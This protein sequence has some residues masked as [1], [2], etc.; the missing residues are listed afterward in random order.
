M[1]ICG[2]ATSRLDPVHGAEGSKLV[3]RVHREPHRQGSNQHAGQNTAEYSANCCRSPPSTHCTFVAGVV[4]I[5]E[6]DECPL[7]GHL[8][9]KP[10]PIT[11]QMDGPRRARVRRM[12]AYCACPCSRCCARTRQVASRSDDPG[13]ISTT[14][15]VRESRGVVE[16]LQ[17]YRTSV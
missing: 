1:I 15:S 13:L 17:S 16:R 8:L 3:V 14:L 10:T 12:I 11:I 9:A 7:R 2:R 6:P 4:L 5:Q